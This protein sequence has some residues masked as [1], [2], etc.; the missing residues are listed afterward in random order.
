[1]PTVLCISAGSAHSGADADGGTDVDAAVLPYCAQLIPGHRHNIIV[2]SVM[3]TTVF[4]KP[5]KPYAQRSLPRLWPS[6]TK[7]HVCAHALSL[8]LA[9]RAC[10]HGTYAWTGAYTGAGAARAQGRA[11]HGAYAARARCAGVG[12]H[13]RCAP[14]R[15]ER[16]RARHVRGDGD[17]RE[18]GTCTRGRARRIRRDGH[19][20]YTGTSTARCIPGRGHGA[21]PGAGAGHGARGQGEQCV[22]GGRGQACGCV[23]L[24]RSGGRVAYETLSARRHWMPH[25]GIRDWWW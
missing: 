18:H 23:R 25:G 1:M 2:S 22:Q 3:C 12:S 24:R 15:G 14:A 4:S 9:A 10:G 6:L 17:G 7:G 21:Y 16:L 5:Q 20:P 19:S 8:P 11:R 13:R